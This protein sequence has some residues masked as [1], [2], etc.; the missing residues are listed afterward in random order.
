MTRIAFKVIIVV[1]LAFAARSRPILKSRIDS[2]LLLADLGSR[3]GVTG[4][5]LGGG[6]A[7]VDEIA[8]A[9]PRSFALARRSTHF[10]HL[11][12]MAT[13]EAASPIPYE[14]QPSTPKATTRPSPSAQARSSLAIA[15]VGGDDHS[16]VEI[17]AEP[18]E[19]DSDMLI[20]V[21]VRRR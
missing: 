16:I 8:L 17:A 4:P 3:R 18:V 15:V 13:Q 1:V 19:G 11:V 21:G 12:A 7:G 20:L 6:V 10:D 9:I 5:H 2:R 14:P